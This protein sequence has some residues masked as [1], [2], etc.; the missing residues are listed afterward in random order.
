MRQAT[1]AVSLLVLGFCRADAIAF[2]PTSYPNEIFCD[3]FETYCADGGYPEPGQPRCTV[4]DKAG[5]N[6]WVQKVW[7]RT[8]G[9]DDGV[10]CGYPMILEDG[11]D[12]ILAG[13]TSGRYVNKGELGQDSV[14]DWVLSEGQPQP[15]LDIHRFIGNVFGEEYASVAA[16][17][18]EPLVM[19]FMAGANFSKLYNSSGYIELAFGDHTNN[20]NR[21]NTDYVK[22]PKDSCTN[23]GAPK[24]PWPLICAQEDASPIMPHMPADAGCPSLVTNPPPVHQAIAVGALAVLD[25][26]PCPSSG[27]PKSAPRNTHLAL[28][29]GQLWWTLQHNR[30][31][32]STGTVIPV[33]GAPMP[34]PAWNF[35]PGDFALSGSGSTNVF[36]NEIRLTV[37][38]NTIKVEL[39]S[40]Q[41]GSNGYTYIVSNTMDNIPRK[42]TGPFDRIRSGVGP[43]CELVTGAGWATCRTISGRQCLYDAEGYFVELDN[44]VLYGG[45]GNPVEGACCNVVDGS[46]T[47]VLQ[48]DC[49]GHWTSSNQR[50][51][52]T[53]CCPRIFGDTNSDGSVDM[54]D[55]AVLQLCTT[56][57]GG[58]M[59]PSCRC[60]DSN[61]DNAINID[62]FEHFVDC[63]NGPE[64]PGNNDTPCAGRGW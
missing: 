28:F 4:T 34:P 33:N 53:L 42:Y 11:A 57:G 44:I 35:Y 16:S 13:V 64:V 7:Y 2:C 15:V 8:S 29:D 43:G 54:N 58:L 12:L 9:S 32:E 6:P 23:S 14:R 47:M 61:G 36:H 21:A 60:F 24:G 26:E 56:T 22:W 59:N 3:D 20:L 10:G 52:N 40:W 1:L 17:D 46:C 62:D 45:Y 50:C 25:T 19:E 39:A 37:K 41:K 51:E 63:A 30:P 27:S 31:A 48:Q 18:S 55:F 38:T 49:T 5:G